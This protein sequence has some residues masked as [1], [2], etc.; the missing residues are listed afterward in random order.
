M[1]DVL[2]RW[3]RL[4]AERVHEQAPKLTALDQAIGDGDHGINLDRGFGAIVAQ[5]DAGRPEADGDRALTGVALRNAGR[6]LISTVGGAAGPL[7]GTAFV[8][9][10]NA[11]VA[12]DATKPDGELLVAALEASIGGI[13]GLGKATTGEKT[14][15][16]ALFRAMHAGQMARDAGFDLAALVAAMADAAEAGATAT[17]PLLA[18]KGRAS[19]LGE[20]SVGHQDPGAT[21][22]A[23][24]LRALSD[25]VSAG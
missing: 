17:V 2:E 9:A 24:L 7:Y 16:D 25:V 5:L 13:A 8:R 6:T 3:L 4:S 18:T 10:G 19:Y 23:L 14:M 20:R 15:L 12:A 1:F 11:I 21:S 22:S